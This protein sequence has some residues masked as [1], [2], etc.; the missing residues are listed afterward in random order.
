VP[1]TNVNC[2]PREATLALRARG[3][4]LSLPFPQ[5]LRGERDSLDTWFG[6]VRTWERSYQNAFNCIPVNFV[7]DNEDRDVVPVIGVAVTQP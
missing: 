2:T 3:A 1:C 5:C 7:L 6:A 4:L